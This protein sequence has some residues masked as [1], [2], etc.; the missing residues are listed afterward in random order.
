M[1]VNIETIA[2]GTTNIGDVDVLS[3]PTG[4]SALQ[5]QGAAAHDAV[6]VG[7][8]VQVGGVYRAT[9]PA[10]ADGD[11]VSLLTDAAGRALVQQVPAGTLTNRSGSITLG[12]TAQQLAAANTARRYLFV[13]NISAGDL[14]INF[15]T[16]AV[17]DQP[18]I[19]MPSGATFD[20]EGSFVSTEAI[21]I[22]GATTGQ[23]F[24]AKEG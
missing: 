5:A 24:V 23:K 21:S 9:A 4:A 11:A 12:G 18:S 2:P 10:V 20:M 13:Q 8:P 17:A 22:I 3:G 1:N 7:N 14:W 16:T 15:T 6:A 19:Q